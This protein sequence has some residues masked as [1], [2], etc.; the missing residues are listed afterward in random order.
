M[1]ESTV[2]SAPSEKSFEKDSDKKSDKNV[3]T[4]INLGCSRILPE[5]SKKQDCL[6]GSSSTTISPVAG[7]SWRSSSTSS[8]TATSSSSST[9]SSSSVTR[10]R[11]Q[12]FIEKVNQ[13]KEMGLN[14]NVAKKVNFISQISLNVDHLKG[15]LLTT[16]CMSLEI[17][18]PS[19]VL[20]NINYTFLHLKYNTCALI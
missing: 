1:A 20:N 19:V 13:L 17:S 16:F 14:E 5:P 18:D 8:A 2:T 7:P 4:V 9:M 15:R 6:N 12:P 3:T 11:P 10:K